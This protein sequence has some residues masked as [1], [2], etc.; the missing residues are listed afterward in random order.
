VLVLDV[1]EELVQ[2]I[3]FVWNPDKLRHLLGDQRPLKMR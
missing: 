2:T 3:R 1:A